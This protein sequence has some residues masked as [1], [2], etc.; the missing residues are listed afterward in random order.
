MPAVDA[1]LSPLVT[2][3]LLEEVLDLVPEAWLARPDDRGAYVKF[4]LARTAN[5]QWLP[6]RAA[7]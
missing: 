4:L 6:G 3:A 5:R 7:A 2:R 1:E